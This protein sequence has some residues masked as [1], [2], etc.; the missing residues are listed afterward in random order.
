ML[1]EKS[2]RIFDGFNKK[3]GNT[4]PVQLVEEDG[5]LFAK[6]VIEFSAPLRVSDTDILEIRDEGELMLLTGQF[7]RGFAG[8]ANHVASTLD[9]AFAQ[10]IAMAVKEARPTILTPTV[11]ETLEINRPNIKFPGNGNG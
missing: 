6:G 11:D 5:D 3:L 8:Y 4:V 2:Q 10:K 7:L 1:N 9:Q